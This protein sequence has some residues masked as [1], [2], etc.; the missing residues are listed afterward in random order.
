MSQQHTLGL[1]PIEAMVNQD[2]ELDWYEDLLNHV[3][4]RLIL[5]IWDYQ[6]VSQQ[7]R[8]YEPDG[9]YNGV[10]HGA[11]L[12]WNQAKEL[13]TEQELEQSLQRMV[14]DPRIPFY[15]TAMSTPEDR[16]YELRW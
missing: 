13:M 4:Q 7:W 12:Q 3:E 5:L 14:A 9:R 10:R 1:D 8:K 11:L 6:Q 15:E 16:R 2:R